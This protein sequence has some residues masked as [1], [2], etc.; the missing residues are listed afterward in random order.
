MG[1]EWE[2]KALRWCFSYHIAVSE[3]CVSAQIGGRD[4]PHEVFDPCV[5]WDLGLDR[6]RS[7]RVVAL[8]RS[9]V[10]AL[11]CCRVVVSLRW[12]VVIKMDLSEENVPVLVPDL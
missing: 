8:S 6:I 10:V 5:R 9:R 3:N 1:T 7:F 2:P 12:R 4:S 11:S